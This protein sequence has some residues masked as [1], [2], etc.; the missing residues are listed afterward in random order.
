MRIVVLMGMLA[1]ALSCHA[2]TASA[3]PDARSES[4]AVVG[5]GCD[6]SCDYCW[7]GTGYENNCPTDWFYDADCD[8]GCQFCD[9][10]CSD[11]AMQ[12]CGA[13]PAE[14]A[15]CC[16]D[17]TCVDAVSQTDCLSADCAFLGSGSSCSQGCPCTDQPLPCDW[18]WLGTSYQYN[19]P[20]DWYGANDGCDCGCQWQDPDCGGGCNPVCGDGACEHDCDEDCSSCPQ[21]CGSCCGNGV[22]D[23][24]EECDD[25]GESAACDADCTWV[26]C[27]DDMLNTSADEEC[28]PP[29]GECCDTTCQFEPAGTAC[30][31]D[32]NP[33][34]DDA[35]NESGMCEQANDDTNDCDDGAFCNGAEY[36]ESGVCVSPGDPCIGGGE[37]R[38]TCNEA[39][40][41][42]LDQANTP[43]GDGPSECSDQ[44]TCD[45]AGDCQVNDLPAGSA[46]GDPSE[47]PCD[48]P[49]SCDGVGAC[50]VNHAPSGAPCDD[51]QPCN[52]V[53]DCDGDGNCVRRLV[54]DCNNNDAE[55]ACDIEDGTSRDCNSNDLPDECDIEQGN[56]TDENGNGIP[57][58][59]DARLDIKPGSCPNPVNPRSNGVVPMAIVGTEPFDVTRIDTDTLLLRRAD[60]V[61][62]AVTPLEGP[63][64]PRITIG[65]VAT[66]LSGDSC[67]CHEVDGDGIDDLLLKFS[68]PDL[69]ET[70]EL[71]NLPR[72]AS[73][74]LM[75]SGS[76]L[77]GTAFEVSDCVVISGRRPT[78]KRDRLGGR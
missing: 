40:D 18:C 3:V 46:C 58:E 77:D 23:G 5:D 49:D 55:D 66:P 69:V 45:G 32:S 35:C 62:G 67:D 50:L 30:S 37:C 47:T 19:C 74:A 10:A 11:C 39:A 24:S 33:C 15:C 63:P 27:G 25:G 13:G 48:A 68:T 6:P 38:Q 1:I 64:G 75:V 34:T 70:L 8:C 16:P 22:L 53:E 44:D 52:G 26:S 51:G 72:G 31:D 43:C 14:G 36:C 42:C 54:D 29:G 20:S 17:L 7:C 76:L 56:S 59:C 41:N 65:D 12:N 61:G 78:G 71:G 9:L 4:L 60:G 2:S 28:E 73:V 21:D 57:D